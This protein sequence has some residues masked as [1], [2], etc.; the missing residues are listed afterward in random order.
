MQI[1]D[2]RLGRLEDNVIRC[3]YMT[4]RFNIHG[5]IWDMFGA[6]GKTRCPPHLLESMPNQAG[7]KMSSATFI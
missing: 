6:I 4:D 3:L 7:F 2:N 5:C 1:E